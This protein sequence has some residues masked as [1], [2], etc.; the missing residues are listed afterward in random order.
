M[1]N[2]AHRSGRRL[3]KLSTGAS[4]QTSFLPDFCRGPV[5]FSLLMVSQMLAFFLVLASPGHELF[6]ASRI[7]LVSLFLHWISLPSAAALCWARQRLMG[8]P[9]FVVAMA[10]FIILLGIT[11]IVSELGFQI[12]RLLQWR[13]FAE[14]QAHGFFILR[15]LILCG[16][17]AVL[18]LYFFY[19]RDAHSRQLIASAEAR[20]AALQARIRPHFFFNSLNSVA[21]L[22]SIRPESAE[23]LLEDLSDL[24]RA[25]LKNREPW[26][27]LEDEVRLAQTYLRIEELRLG[28]RLQQDWQL[29]DNM[30]GLRLPLL[31]LQP[32]VENAVYHGIERLPQGGRIGIHIQRQARQLIVEV[33]NPVPVDERPAP[34]SRI[35]LDNIRQRLRLLYDDKATLTTH[36][37]SG[38]YRAELRIPA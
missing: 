18:L 8:R 27:S 4:Q 34:G 32:L 15:N 24:F 37:L 33:S 36:S 12:G 19:L 2:A 35:A 22:I 5:I 20:F 9:T 14:S 10:A 30:Q 23:T 21:A 3:M 28:E 16:L 13:G 7:I 11:G 6:P 25:I 38:T 1:R 17:V 31:S 26:N 29:P